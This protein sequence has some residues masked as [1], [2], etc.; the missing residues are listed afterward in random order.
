MSIFI[1]L[2]SSIGIFMLYGL[3]TSALQGGD[4]KGP[5]LVNTIL[6]IGMVA[7]IIAIWRQKSNK[8]KGNEMLDKS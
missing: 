8:N 6:S 3:L 1:K 5:S 4:I 2:I 7:G